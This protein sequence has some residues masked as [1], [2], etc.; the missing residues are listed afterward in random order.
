MRR[1]K[2]AVVMIGVGLLCSGAS[3]LLASGQGRQQK[4]ATPSAPPNNE[5]SIRKDMVDHAQKAYDLMLT[6]HNEG[7]PI[8]FEDL[9]RWSSRRLASELELARDGDARTAALRAHLDR[10]KHVESQAIDRAKR[11]GVGQSSDVSACKYYRAEAELWVAL[12]GMKH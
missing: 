6:W 12:G 2:A 10:M 9:N 4:E 7:G 11:M 8:S 1:T 3:Y 5:A